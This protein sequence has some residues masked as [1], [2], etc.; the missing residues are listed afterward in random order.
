MSGTG[1]GTGTLGAAA[2]AAGE[3]ATFRAGGIEVPRPMRAAT[4]QLESAADTTTGGGSGFLV[5]A[6]G[7]VLAA[8]MLLLVQRLRG[9]ALRLR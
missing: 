5:A 6:A 7:A 2:P 9:R 1:T 8:T 3:I 4:P